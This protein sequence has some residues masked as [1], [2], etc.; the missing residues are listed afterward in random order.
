MCEDLG[1]GPGLCP[2]R[3]LG[4]LHPQRMGREPGLESRALGPFLSPAEKAARVNT[5]RCLEGAQALEKALQT[6]EVPR[7]LPACPSV[8]SPSSSSGV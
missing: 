1:M 3:P 4:R 6:G 7:P 2:E 8:C 5:G